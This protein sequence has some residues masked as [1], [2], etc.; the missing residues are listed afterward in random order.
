M[1]VQAKLTVTLKAND[2]LVAESEDA[3]LWQKVLLAITENKE[4]AI[5]INKTDLP[6][7]NEDEVTDTSALGKYADEIGLDVATV[8]GACDPSGTAPYMQLDSHCWSDW[9]SNV[10]VRGRGSISPIAL[11]ATLLVLWFKK[12]NLGTAT[13]DQAQAV[14]ANINA[15]GSNPARSIN[16]CE[17]LQRRND[18]T[19]L[20]NPARIKKAIE[21]ARA[22]CIREKPDAEKMK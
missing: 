14:L 18:G 17:W 3:G 1:T 21:V 9:V 12:A 15:I 5:T 11:A 19:V 8:K 2:V 10:P 7:L 22:F 6:P 4:L 16:N 20:L 13:Q